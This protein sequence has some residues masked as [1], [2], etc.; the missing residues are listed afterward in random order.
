LF[1]LYVLMLSVWVTG[2]AS[3]LHKTASQT[4][5]VRFMKPGLTGGTLKEWLIK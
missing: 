5:M 1:L 4:P 3:D 2:R